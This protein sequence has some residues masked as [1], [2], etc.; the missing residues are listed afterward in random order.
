MRT[1]ALGMAVLMASAVSAQAPDQARVNAIWS[2]AHDRFLRQND[3]WYKDGDFPRAIQ[4]L[5]VLNGVFPND[6]EIATDL[7][8]MLENVEQWDEAL[9]VYA[10]YRKDNPKDPNAAFPEAWYYF[11][12]RKYD[13]IPPLLEPTMK[14]GTSPHPNSYRTLAH[15]YDRLKRY[16]DA[17]RVWQRYIQLAPDD[18][19][20]KVNL[21]KVERK[22]KGG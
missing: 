5:R 18:A 19:T 22:L 14:L 20:A 13:K 16:A 3:L 17:K 7:G 12:K 4:S 15:A 9:T 6:Y 2:I 10:R 21:Q 8:W 11:Q 1:I